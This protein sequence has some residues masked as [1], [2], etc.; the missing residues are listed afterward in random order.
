MLMDQ[1]RSGEEPVDA[2][3]EV[4]F[5]ELHHR[6]YNSLQAISFMAG[7][8]ARS[9][10]APEMLQALQDRIG[11]FA[12]IHRLLSEPVETDGSL[13]PACETLCAD[14]LRAFDREQSR[15]EIRMEAFCGDPMTGRTILLLIVELVT[16]AL[17][18]AG[19][20]APQRILVS[21][22]ATDGGLELL[23]ANSGSGTTSAIAA[24]PAM[25]KCLARSLGG[26]LT[27]HRGADFEVRVTLPHHRT[28]SLIPAARR[29]MRPATIE[30]VSA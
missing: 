30:G 17:K 25:A 10:A 6:F 8:A 14:L 7:T 24:R 4:L 28:A 1:K 2:V 3:Q 23:V 9:G 26:A 29:W 18:H 11:A 22:A 16:N 5:R 13:A 20:G 12:R 21:L 27:V 19:R 15:V